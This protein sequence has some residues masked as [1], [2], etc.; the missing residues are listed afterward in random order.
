MLS[1]MPILP[2]C[3]RGCGNF[4]SAARGGLCNACAGP[5]PPPP[6]TAPPPTSSTLI[7]GSVAVLDTPALHV[8]ALGVRDSLRA[9]AV[10]HDFVSVADVLGGRLTRAP[11]ACLVVP[12]GDPQPVLDE[13]GVAGRHA[14]HAFLRDGGGYVGICAGANV[15]VELGLVRLQ[16]RGS[17]W[18]HFYKLV[19]KTRHENAPASNPN[20][21]LTQA[22]LPTPCW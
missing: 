4:G 11:F 2:K 15:A 3:P 5:L 6:E 16:R 8:S 17:N 9:G 20:S 10:P 22:A 21:A 19:E 13:L 14:I 18:Y 7:A 12:G 1:L